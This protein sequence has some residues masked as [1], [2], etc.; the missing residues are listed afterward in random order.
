MSKLSIPRKFVP[1][2]W[3][4]AV[5]VLAAIGVAGGAGLRMHQR[6]RRCEA[7]YSIASVD[8]G[9]ERQGSRESGS[10]AARL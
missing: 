1:A 6:K 10:F 4:V 9:N 8:C 3:I 5:A 2:G 7:H